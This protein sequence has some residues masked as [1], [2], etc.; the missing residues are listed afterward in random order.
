VGSEEDEVTWY[1]IRETFDGSERHYVPFEG[2]GIY[3]EG[4]IGDL[5]VMSYPKDA[6][7]DQLRRFM[8]S[9]RR[10]RPELKGRCVVVRDDVKFMRFEPAT[11]DEVRRLGEVPEPE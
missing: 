8:K 3:V 11:E 10:E 7:E 6:D 5:V 2:T 1:K 9:L 4:E